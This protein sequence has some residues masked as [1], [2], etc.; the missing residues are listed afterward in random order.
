MAQSRNRVKTVQQESG[1]LFK[2]YPSTM[3]LKAIRPQAYVVQLQCDRCARLAKDGEPEFLEFSSIEYTAGYGSILGDC[4]RVAIDLCQH[5][6][7]KVLGPWLRIAGPFAEDDNLQHALGQ[8][9]PAKHGGEFPMAQDLASPGAESSETAKYETP[10]PPEGFCTWLDYAVS[11]ADLRSAQHAFLFSDQK[12]PSRES[13][14]EALG[15]ELAELLSAASNFSASEQT[16]DNARK[17]PTASICLNVQELEA[18]SKFRHEATCT[19]DA[20]LLASLTE[21]GTALRVTCSKNCR[22]PMDITDYS[23]W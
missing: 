16:L 22:S 12:M 20:R 15:R 7:Q 18:L 14:R 11:T 8:F 1:M 21:I 2:Q 17:L 13:M 3:K 9:D 10:K 4:N 6:L 23:T 19:G 5:C